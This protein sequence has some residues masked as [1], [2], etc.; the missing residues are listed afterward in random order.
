MESFL[1]FSSK[2][3]NT[4]RRLAIGWRTHSV[5]SDAGLRLRKKVSQES[6]YGQH[7]KKSCSRKDRHQR[8]LKAFRQ[9]PRDSL[10]GSGSSHRR[11]V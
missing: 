2:R 8:S 4:K 7:W 9:R 1:R 5:D 11:A 10:R 6:N 3:S